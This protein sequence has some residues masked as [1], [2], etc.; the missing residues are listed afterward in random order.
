MQLMAAGAPPRLAELASALNAQLPVMFSFAVLR[1]IV[2]SS[3]ACVCAPFIP[4]RLKRAL[5]QTRRTAMAGG[6]LLVVLAVAQ[7]P[8]AFETCAVYVYQRGQGCVA[9]YAIT[10][11]VSSNRWLASGLAV[12][13]LRGVGDLSAAAVP[14]ALVA[15][16]AACDTKGEWPCYLLLIVY[17]LAHAVACHNNSHAEF[18]HS[19]VLATIVLALYA[20]ARAWFACCCFPFRGGLELSRPTRPRSNSPLASAAATPAQSRPSL[21]PR[22]RLKAPSEPSPSREE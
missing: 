9:L 18:T 22:L 3:T 17:T 8:P 14:L 2:W 12:A 4:M 21:L 15:G 20:F 7:E 5:A 11:L 13:A 16:Y 1:W 6:T 19:T 10:V